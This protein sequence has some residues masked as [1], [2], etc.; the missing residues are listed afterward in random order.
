MFRPA[1]AGIA[2]AAVAALATTVNAGIAF[3]SEP[4]DSLAF[5]DVVALFNAPG[6]S[7]AV[8]GELTPG[9]VDWFE[10]TFNGPT[11]L[12]ITALGTTEDPSDA[13][14]QLMLVSGDGTDVIEF[15][16]DD[17]PG[18]LPVLLATNLPGGTYFIGVSGFDDIS[19][20]DDPVT[21]DEL[22]DGLDSATGEPHPQ[23]FTYKLSI[24]ANLVPTPSTGL[25]VGFAGLAALRRRR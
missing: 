9:D 12:L 13:D 10:I 1:P 11:T 7:I 3:E 5:A 15:D 2:A 19:F 21:T 20:P 18:F 22:F 23:N 24:A 14:G 4:N 25:I 6:G 8:D 16:D 17:G